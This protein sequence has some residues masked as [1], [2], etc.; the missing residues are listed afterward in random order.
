MGARRAAEWRL[1]AALTGR[2]RN[3]REAEC[4]HGSG[5]AAAAGPHVA[6][7]PG[8]GGTHTHT[9]SVPGRSVI[10]PPTPPGGAAAALPAEAGKVGGAGLCGQPAATAAGGGK[11]PECRSLSPGR[12]GAAHLPAPSGPEGSLP[13]QGPF[14]RAP[15]PRWGRVQNRAWFGLFWF[16]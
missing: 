3:W 16:C 2:A 1:P 8:G 9:A 12:T 15:A 14:T 7:P 6:A 11:A 10:P 4:K 5:G 13:G